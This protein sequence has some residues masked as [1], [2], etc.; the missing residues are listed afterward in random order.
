MAP[1]FEDTQKGKNII[2]RFLQYREGD[3]LMIRCLVIYI[4]AK[5]QFTMLTPEL[6][7]FSFS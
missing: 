6:A 4:L 2:W 1:N 7:I 3:G 5:L